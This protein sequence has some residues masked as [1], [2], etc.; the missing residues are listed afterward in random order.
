MTKDFTISCL[1]FWVLRYEI[2]EYKWPTNFEVMAVNR[3]INCGL[4]VF[5]LITIMSSSLVCNFGGSP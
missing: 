2:K 5:R 3:L 1:I 4:W